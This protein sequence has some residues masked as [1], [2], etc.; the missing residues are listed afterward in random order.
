M[1]RV[2]VIGFVA[3]FYDA[4]SLVFFTVWSVLGLV[5]LGYVGLKVLRMSDEEWER[6]ASKVG[7]VT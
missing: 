6:P 3:G 1:P 5:A 4:Y 7:E 2:L